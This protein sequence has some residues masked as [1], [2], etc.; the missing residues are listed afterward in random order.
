MKGDLYRRWLLEGRDLTLEEF[1]S[2]ERQR[3]RFL[4]LQRGWAAQMLVTAQQQSFQNALYRGHPLHGSGA[5][6]SSLLGGL[7][8]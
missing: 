5:I 3:R 8:R 7:F 6:L 4:R 1:V 2:E